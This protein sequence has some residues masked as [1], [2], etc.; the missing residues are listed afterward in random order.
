MRLQPDEQGGGFAEFRATFGGLFL[1]AHVV[2]LYFTAKWIIGGE[3]VIGVFAAGAGAVLCAAWVGTAFGRTYSLLRDNTR[4]Q[5][6][7]ISVC[8]ELL[9]GAMIGAPWALWNFSA[10]S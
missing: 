4:T 10:P 8:V 6:N 3:S 5:F 9:V 2:A 7:M 1:A